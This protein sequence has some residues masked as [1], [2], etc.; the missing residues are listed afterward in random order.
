MFTNSQKL[1]VSVLI[2]VVL[3]SLG[4]SDDTGQVPAG[5]NS[6]AITKPDPDPVVVT[7]TVVEIADE[8]PVDGGVIIDLEVA[9][10]RTEVLYLPSFFTTPP[11]P[12]N[13]QKVYQVIVQLEVGNRVKAEGCRTEHG[14]KLESLDILD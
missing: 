10:G 8:V 14:I 3:I 2:F 1:V 5:L 6:D 9:D 4:C 13:N 12:E 7:G 11:P